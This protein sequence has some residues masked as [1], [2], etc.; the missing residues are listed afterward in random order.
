MQIE[1]WSD[2]ACP[3]CYIGKTRLENA[4]K[5]TGN[6]HIELVYKAYQLDPT[7]PKKSDVVAKDYYM[8]LKGFS[9]EKV[10]QL[11]GQIE[12]MAAQSGLEYHMDKTI[13]TNS[14]DAHRL[15]K[16]ADTL[17]KEA[18]LT[19]RLMVAY[20]KEGADLADHDTLLSLVKEMGLDDEAAA[21]VLAD[22]QAFKQEVQAQMS[23][24]REIGVSGVP[25]FVI[26]RKYGISG[27][28]EEALFLQALNQVLEEEKTQ[29]KSF[30]SANGASCDDESCQIE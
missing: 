18:E 22:P 28:Q 3:F 15:A 13:H 1:I 17:G 6:Q 10:A 25:F 11:F 12:A 14:F 9:A 2:F 19:T 30:N 21:K 23:E 5:K 8:N 20:F 27:A 7:A 24:A 29:L 16:W 26:N 4:I